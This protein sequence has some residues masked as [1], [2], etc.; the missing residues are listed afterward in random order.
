[1]TVLIIEHCAGVEPNWGL[2]KTYFTQNMMASLDLAILVSCVYILLHL[3]LCFLKK[4][5][6]H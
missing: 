5:C 4:M 3:Y 1:M 6:A 2:R